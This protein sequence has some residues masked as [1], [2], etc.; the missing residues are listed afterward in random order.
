M[1]DA[2]MKAIGKLIGKLIGKAA[3]KAAGSALL[4]GLL[5]GC[6]ATPAQEAS[7][8]VT[9]EWI[10][11]DRVA[12]VQFRGNHAACHSSASSIDSYERCM[13]DRGYELY[14]P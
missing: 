12:E 8:A 6:T 4:L 5:A 14:T 11:S 2:F 13:S 10:S 7:H 3:G 9:H 1:L